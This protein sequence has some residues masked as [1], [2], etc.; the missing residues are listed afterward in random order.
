MVWLHERGHS[1]GLNHPEGEGQPPFTQP[2]QI[3]KRVMFWQIALGH[4]GLN[5]NECNALLRQ[6]FV[7]I[8]IVPEGAA[9]VEAVQ[10]GTDIPTFG[11]TERAFQV[12]GSPWVHG[13]PVEAIKTLDEQDLNSIRT[14]LSGTPNPYWPNA[15]SVLGFRGEPNDAE[16]IKRALELP[17]AA[18]IGGSESDQERQAQ[19]TLL[20]IKLRAPEAM[21]ILANKTKDPELVERLK[22][23]TGLEEARRLTQSATGADLLSKSA[24]RG[25]ALSGQPS[26]DPVLQNTPGASGGAGL[27]VKETESLRELSRSIK[28]LGLDR[29]LKA[30][31]Q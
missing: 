20:T 9:A 29:T 21:G 18:T 27:T 3:A 13:M 11:L 19:R 28:E 22:N 17:M 4:F 14:M 1:M 8:G 25:L 15:L 26:A 16:L 31:V 24:L 6:Q 10:L 5:T 7:S 2:E 30:P 12:V 23:I